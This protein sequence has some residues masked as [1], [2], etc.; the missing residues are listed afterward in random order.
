MIKKVNVPLLSI[1]ILNSMSN[2][3]DSVYCHYSLTQATKYEA[4][5]IKHCSE[6]L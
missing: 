2:T 3:A 1:A 6:L 5:H 4:G